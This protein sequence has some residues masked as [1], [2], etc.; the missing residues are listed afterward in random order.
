MEKLS[1][2]QGTW[3]GEAFGGHTEEIWSAPNA[4][5]MMFSFKLTQNNTPVFYEFGFILEQE[6]TL[7]LKLKHF[8]PDLTGWE[9]KNKFVEFKL[10][11]QSENIVWFEGFTIEK[12][13]ND[14]INMYVRIDDENK[15]E[16]VKF[17]Y[18]RAKLA[19]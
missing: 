15:V 11:E 10:V 19:H 12:I 16:E 8:N 5:S 18:H 14:E 4:G 13:N 3:H 9:E 7:V 6:G 2:L 17:N 1:W